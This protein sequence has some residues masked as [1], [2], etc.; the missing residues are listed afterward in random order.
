MKASFYKLCPN[1]NVWLETKGWMVLTCPLETGV[2]KLVT[3]ARQALLLPPIRI[4]LATP[5]MPCFSIDFGNLSFGFKQ[6]QKTQQG[7][8]PPQTCL[9]TPQNWWQA[10]MFLPPAI[11]NGCP[12]PIFLESPNCPSVIFSLAASKFWESTHF[13]QSLLFTASSQDNAPQALCAKYLSKH[14]CSAGGESSSREPASDLLF[15][16]FS[17]DDRPATVWRNNRHLMF[18]VGRR[19]MWINFV[20]GCCYQRIFYTLPHNTFMVSQLYLHLLYLI[21]AVERR[22]LQPRNSVYK[23]ATCQCFGQNKQI[24]NWAEKKINRCV[25]PLNPPHKF[26]IFQW[27]WLFTSISTQLNFFL[28]QKPNISH[29]HSA[30]IYMEAVKIMVRLKFS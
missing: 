8:L 7:A 29:I 22:E 18:A 21:F 23:L 27:I 25:I 20:G 3:S 17:T 11:L 30:Q 16:W 28:Q 1:T 10:A 6:I 15:C 13:L 2:W 26:K 19:G 9:S 24:C 14:C 12:P 5:D 4:R